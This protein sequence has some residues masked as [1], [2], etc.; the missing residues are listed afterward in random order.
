MQS[1]FT[2]LR[3]LRGSP[4]LVDLVRE[5]RLSVRDFVFPLF[6]IHGRGKRIPVDPMPGI[7]QISVDRLASEVKEI[8]G[9][10]IPAVLLFG[11]PEHKDSLGTEGVGVDGIIQRAIAEIK[12]AAPDMVVIT[13]VCLCDYT[14]HGHC[15]ILSGNIVD[16]DKTLRVLSE[17]AV[18]H[19]EAGADIVAPSAMMDGQVLAIRKALDSSDH[20]TS[21]IMSYS[22]KY[23]S[24]FYGPFRVAAESAPQF[25]D[26]NGYQ[27]DVSNRRQAMIEI[28]QDIL[29][30]ADIVMVKPALAILDVLKE[31][32]ERVNVPIAAY[33]VSGEYS[34]VK[35]AADNEWI[36]GQKITREIL[37]S[38]KRGGADI[39]ITYHAKE[40]ARALH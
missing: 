8:R 29:E 14:D 22:A 25:G 19:A 12:S 3:R 31:A 16:N 39:I 10:G 30:G 6:V 38:I 20:T 35:A 24:G 15:G 32:R 5:S 26:R 34:M 37:T 36:D 11:I 28:E 17:M 21:P 33:N 40:M 27:M 13:D 1:T 23:A 4:E 9:L 2:R 18:S 7:Y